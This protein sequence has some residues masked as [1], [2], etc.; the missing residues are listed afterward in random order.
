MASKR[1]T[2]KIDDL[3]PQ[4]ASPEQFENELKS[5]ASKAQ[6]DS[7]E[8]WILKQLALYFK[9]TTLLILVAAYSNVSYLTLSPVY[10]SI[11]S[12]VWHSKVIMG[13][14]FAGWS[15]NI[16]LNR[17][18]PI[19]PAH[20]LPVIAMWIP[21]I[22]FFLFGWSNTF[23]AH[24]GPLVTEL[25][26]LFPLV[27]ISAA[28]VATML[29][30]A[31]LSFLPQFFAEAGPAMHNYH[32]MSPAATVGL[33]YTLQADNWI[34][35]D[36]RESLTGYIS[37]IE[38]LDKGFRVMR[39]DHSLLGGEWMKVRPTDPRVAEPIYGVFV[40]L[41]ATRLV[42]VTSPVPD[43]EAKA[44]IDPVVHEFAS[45][46]FQLPKNHTAVIDD[47]V[48]YTASL[49]NDAEAQYDYI[50]HDVFTGGAEP[51]PLFTLEFLQGLSSLLKPDG[52]IA[53]DHRQHYPGGVPFVSYLP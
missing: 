35:L 5:L 23:T 51:I 12:S 4:P 47:A 17:A 48:S 30:D 43:N 39:C 18:L 1:K 45:K 33:N 40:M 42:E 41:E 26:T 20:L 11:P 37:V 31:D 19:K 21:T 24:Y 7:G 22:Q 14:A 27:A 53:I 38:S 3:T 50:V 13:A 46:Y 29:E 32:V 15:G 16:W 25:L 8:S 36:R 34:L 49:V 28:T 2:G 9:T 6:K 44:L 10:G 52:V